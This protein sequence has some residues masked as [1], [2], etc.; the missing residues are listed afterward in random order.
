MSS[1]SKAIANMEGIKKLPLV[2]DTKALKHVFYSL[3]HTSW[4]CSYHLGK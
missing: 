1:L 2:V 4:L 3:I